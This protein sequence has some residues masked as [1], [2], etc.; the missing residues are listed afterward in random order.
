MPLASEIMT[1]EETAPESPPPDAPPA[2][3]LKTRVRTNVGPALFTRR[4]E[5]LG[6]LERA[7]TIYRYATNWHW[8]GTGQ[9]YEILW[10]DTTN[11]SDLQ[12]LARL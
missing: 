12:P 11:W 9:G 1:W 8:T 6:L 3:R 7:E 4:M 5:Q 2:V 10:R